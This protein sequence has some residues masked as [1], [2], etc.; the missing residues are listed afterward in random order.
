MVLSRIKRE[1]TQ[2]ARQV[3]GDN[4]IDVGLPT[5]DRYGADLALPLFAAAKKRGENPN[6][7]AQRVSETIKHPALLRASA[8]AGFVNFFLN[9]E[10]LGAEIVAEAQRGGQDTSL[11]DKE[12]IVEFTDPNPFKEFHIGHLY[13]NTVGEAI[14]RLYESG[15]ARAHR[16][17]Y[18]G[19]VG[20]H[21]AKAVWGIQRLLDGKSMSEIKPQDRPRFLG[22]AYALG[23]RAYEDGGATKRE[24]DKLNKLI[25]QNDPSVKEIYETGKDWSFSYFDAIYE[26]L[27]MK[28]EKRYLE[29][30]SARLA[31]DLVR[32]H[33]DVF[34]PSD[35]AIVFRGERLGLHTRVFITQEGLPTYE[36]KDL[37]LVFIKAADYPNFDLSL[38][39]TGNEQNEYFKV[40]LAALAEIDPKLADKT[41]HLGH[42]VVRLKHGKM[43]SRTGKVVTALA[44]LDSVKEAI[45]E[46]YQPKSLEDNLLGAVKYSMLKAKIGGNIVYDIEESIS[47]D[48]DSGPYI[49][50]AGARINSILKKAPKG[51]AVS[52][53]DWREE[54]RLLRQLAYY[55]EV[56]SEARESLAPHLI[57]RYLYELARE[58]NRYYEQ[59]TVLKSAASARAA[60][61]ALL[62]A[63][64]QTLSSGLALL[65]IN[66]PE[67]M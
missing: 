53:Y 38:I 40:M 65:N 60:R 30:E 35:G 19:D 58:L 44:L 37:G 46:R 24:I 17:S 34:E 18:H 33:H 48:G 62:K 25:Y 57:A 27:G 21:V 11:A 9:Y 2:A 29:S 49:Q 61:L 26:R 54:K 55:P 13:S 45:L 59:V 39:I 15:G 16:V 42:G 4:E 8:A 31:L 52:G 3:V 67:E 56:V 10:R 28:F 43:S 12:I 32:R 51:E 64:R 7:L 6:Q 22:R 36:A 20:L 66:L 50:Y 63:A 14:A 5:D 41:R 23:A 1:L 47:L